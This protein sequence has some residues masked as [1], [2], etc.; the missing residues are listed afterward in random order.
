[1]DT[2]T[3]RFRFLGTAL[4]T[5]SFAVA[6]PATQVEAQAQQT[7]DATSDLTDERLTQYA[8][9]HQAINAARDEFQ[10]AKAGV[11]DSEARE[12][13]REEMDERLHGLYEEHGMAKE[14]Y[15]AITFM[16]S[17]DNEVRTRVEEITATLMTPDER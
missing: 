13:L 1:M 15:D 10:A 3:A 2:R 4:L 8:Q 5:A 16:V 6:A 12:R 9:L 7:A 11:H 17:I 14:D